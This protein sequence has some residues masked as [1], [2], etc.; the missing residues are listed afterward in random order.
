MTYNGT[1]DFTLYNGGNN[2][3]YTTNAY[4]KLGT[5][6]G[7]NGTYYT[8]QAAVNSAKTT[9]QQT[10]QEYQTWYTN[11]TNH[12]LLKE[13]YDN[14]NAAVAAWDNYDQSVTDHENSLTNSFCLNQD[15]ITS[16]NPIKGPDYHQV[17]SA[18]PAKMYFD[19]TNTTYFPIKTTSDYQAS[20]ENTGYFTSGTTDVTYSGTDDSCPRSIIISS[21]DKNAKLK[22]YSN[23][24]FN[25]ADIYTIDDTN[26]GNPHALDTTDQVKYSKYSSS[27]KG[28]EDVL[29]DGDEIGGFHFF[30][31]NA[32]EGSKG[33]ISTDSIVEA[34]DIRINGEEYRSYELPVYA[35]DFQ[36]KEKGRINF[37]AGMYNGGN[38]YGSHNSGGSSANMNGFFSFHRVFRDS[39]NKITDIREVQAIYV[40]NSKNKWSCI[41]EYKNGKFSKPY[42]TEGKS[43][44]ELSADDTGTT[45]YVENHD[46]TS[47]STYLASPYNYT[48]A[49]DT[50]W[51]AYYDFAANSD[52]WGRV[53]YFE[54]PADKGEYCLGAYEI[55]SSA[56]NNTR[57]DGAYLMYLDIGANA[58]KTQ[59]TIIY[60]HYNEI[61]K[62]FEYP[63]GIAVVPVS[64]VTTNITNGTNIDET[65]TANFL[66]IAGNTSIGAVTVKRVE[67]DVT[68][69]R[70]GGLEDKAKPTLVGD[71]MKDQYN[72]YNIHDPGGNNLTNEITSQNTTTDVRRLEYYD[73]NVIYDELMITHIIDTSTDGTNYT[74][75][76]YQQYSDGSSTT[77]LADMKIY[78]TEGGGRISSANLEDPAT[79]IIKTYPGEN[80]S[81]VNTTVLL[82]IKYQ[83]DDGENVVYDWV[84]S[85]VVDQN[86]NTGRFYIFDGYT[87]Q[88]TLENGQ[89]VLEVL[90]KGSKTVYIN[91]T[92]IT[93]VGQKVTLTATP[94]NP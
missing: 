91:G 29:D 24:K 89:V 8:T 30:S 7:F 76:F 43:T 37:F 75:T 28:L 38:D 2:S 71:T 85:M 26:S 5:V 32:K 68:L 15:N 12:N 52:Y 11:Y 69:T 49:F 35:L 51:L 86:N 87:F 55:P 40:N 84:L 25:D 17:G 79:S 10:S 72:V 60:E 44:Y 6:Y 65:N 66:I 64:T 4:F 41:F 74:R 90:A 50:D 61:K 1:D 33:M 67:D 22:G 9:Y 47:I 80:A 92:A 82:T 16:D 31:K 46:L 48:K 14:Y 78:N 27:K 58:A 53:F 77:T 62:V 94:A 39:S 45:P 56:P 34:R 70:T 73:Y 93:T 63:I 3:N 54:M 23:D 83:E 19:Y 59:R 18:D 36:L 21:Y 13:E 81:S 57:M 20:K 88:A 42:K